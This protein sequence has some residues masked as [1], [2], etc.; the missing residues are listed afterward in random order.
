MATAKPSVRRND[1]TADVVF[2][3]DL[4]FGRRRLLRPDDGP[5]NDSDGIRTDFTATLLEPKGP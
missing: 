1:A 3:S 2:L 5:R 4:R